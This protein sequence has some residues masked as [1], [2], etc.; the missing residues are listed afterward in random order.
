MGKIGMR[1]PQLARQQQK[2]RLGMLTG[3]GCS[4]V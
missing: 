2:M 3:Y 1:Q 4:D